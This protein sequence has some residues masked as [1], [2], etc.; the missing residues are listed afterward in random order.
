MANQQEEAD[1]NSAWRNLAKSIGG[2]S[3]NAGSVKR[4]RDT[5][6]KKVFTPEQVE[7]KHLLFKDILNAFKR[8]VEVNFEAGI[9]QL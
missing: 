4:I 1:D 3:I 8:Q 6:G 7:E 2:A 9:I 5:K